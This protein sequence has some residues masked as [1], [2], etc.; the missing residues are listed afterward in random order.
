MTLKYKKNKSYQ[1]L[2][3]QFQAWLVSDLRAYGVLHVDGFIWEPDSTCFV[4]CSADADWAIH[5]QDMFT[6]QPWTGAASELCILP[7]DAPLSMHWRLLK[8]AGQSVL[9]AHGQDVFHLVFNNLV[10]SMVWLASIQ[11][12]LAHGSYLMHQQCKYMKPHFKPCLK[13][14]WFTGWSLELY[15]PQKVYQKGCFGGVTLTA[16]EQ[17]YLDYF[18]LGLTYREI[19]VRHGVSEVAV[20]KIYSNI[21]RKLKEPKLPSSQLLSRLH[22][23]GFVPHI[24]GV[25]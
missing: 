25:L 7:M 17:R 3:D 8:G 6:P 14:G 20:R 21:K 11:R 4:M 12:S 16:K 10:D 2:C 18:A 13:E 5:C 23:Y 22:R 24:G 9:W 1:Q 19:A 15:P